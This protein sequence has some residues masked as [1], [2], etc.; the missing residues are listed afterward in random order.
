MNLKNKKIGIVLS[1]GGMRAV[2]YHLGVLKWLAEKN[3]M[4]SITYISSVSG[5]S[6]CTGLLYAHNNKKWP[7]SQQYLEEVLP[8][9]EEIILTS[10]IQLSAL[11]RMFPFWMHRKVNLLAKVLSK[12][13][14]VSGTMSELSKVPIW[15]AN[16]TTYETGK[17]F[18]ITQDTMGDIVIGYARD[19]NFPISDAMAA[20]AGFPLL[21]G[22]Y[23]LRRGN[24]SW[25]ASTHVETAGARDN[26]IPG[27]RNFYLWDGGVHDNMGLEAL[28]HISDHPTGGHLS[29]G[30]EYIIVSNAGTLS[31]FRR[32]AFS[33]SIRRLL[34]IAMDQVS[35]LRIRSIV[36]H[37]RHEHNGLYLQIGE[38]ASQILRN[39]TIDPVV[40][41][42]II[43]ESIPEHHAVY[44][45]NYH[46]TLRRPT[47]ADYRILFRHG[48]DVARSAFLAV[49]V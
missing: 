10:D 9:V 6:L 26:R 45:R 4:E 12:K 25:N 48:Y 14:G 36:G 43:S 20:S 8:K 49:N 22:P 15:S 3:L 32:R 34:N 28:F 27:G 2:I 29:Q 30:I 47:K 33:S 37:I 7:T 1:G 11:L 5:G 17:R 35:I 40:K 13:W 16:C 23:A 41:K 19:H 42:Q 18:G 38:T 21:I 44:A 46:T 39:S 31:R 24:Y